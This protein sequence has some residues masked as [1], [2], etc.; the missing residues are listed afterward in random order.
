MP[1]GVSTT[2]AP[3]VVVAGAGP[4]GC[5]AAAV[6]VKNNVRVTLLEAAPSLPVELRASTFHPATL[7][8]LRPYDVVDKMI[9]RGRIAR[10]V[11]Y[12]ERQRGVGA[13]FDPC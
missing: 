7:E 1:A 5:V 8:L 12:R 4:V 3:H 2:I 10:H 11:C 6:L 9:C 13:L